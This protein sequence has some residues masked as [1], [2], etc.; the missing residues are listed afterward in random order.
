MFCLELLERKPFRINHR[1]TIGKRIS[2][3]SLPIWGILALLFLHNGISYILLFF[4]S[5]LVGTILEGALGKFIRNTFGVK[6]WTYK[7]G[8][9]GNFT[10]I[11]AIP[12]WG[13]AGLVFALLGKYIGL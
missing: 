6:V 1:F 5:A 8:T 4:A 11:Y 3:V 12:Y 9:I 7:K 2:L 10:S 13:A